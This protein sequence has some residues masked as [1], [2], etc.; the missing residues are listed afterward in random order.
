M[1]CQK[2]DILYSGNYECNSMV[3]IL[4]SV[5]KIIIILLHSIYFLL[6]FIS[7]FYIYIVGTKS[8]IN[9]SLISHIFFRIVLRIRYN[10]NVYYCLS[11]DVRLN[12]RHII[13]VKNIICTI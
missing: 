7:L 11:A 9:I 4:Y 2:Y 3:I 13:V 12:N 5:Y 1:D 6:I 8:F 10:T